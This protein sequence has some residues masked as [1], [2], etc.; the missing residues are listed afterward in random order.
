MVLKHGDK[1][2]VTGD[3]VTDA[4]RFSDPEGL[5]FGYV[6]MLRDMLWARHPERRI[7]V[8]N[9]GFAGSTV[10][11][12]AERWADEILVEKPQ[13][14]CICI[15]V[16]D[17]WRQAA[18]PRR[19]LD[20]A[21]AEFCTVYTRLIQRAREACAPK[22]ILCEPTPAGENRDA[23]H[24]GVALRYCECVQTLAAKHQALLA[25]MNKAF[26]SAIDSDPMRSWTNDGIHPLSAGHM[27]LALTLYDALDSTG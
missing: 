5:G 17:A 7:E 27:L 3:S 22:L 26:W 24:Y 20:E 15:G 1:L 10:H 4:G 8:L 9:R 21:V 12:L 18:N 16:N 13:W 2:L 6:R 25:P 23:A 19:P 14:L 11:D